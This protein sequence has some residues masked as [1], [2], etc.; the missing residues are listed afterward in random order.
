[1]NLCLLSPRR[2]SRLH[3]ARKE[4][5]LLGN[6]EVLLLDNDEPVTYA[7]VMMDLDFEKWQSDLELG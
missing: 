3:E 4:V 6:G 7:E 1:M 5:L 2:S